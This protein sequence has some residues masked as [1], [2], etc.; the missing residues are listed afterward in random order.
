MLYFLLTKSLSTCCYIGGIS[1][2]L[3]H[4]LDQLKPQYIASISS[5]KQWTISRFPMSVPWNKSY[6]S[7]DGSST[8]PVIHQSSFLLYGLPEELMVR[9]R[10]TT[11][12]LIKLLSLT[13]CSTFSCTF[14]I[15]GMCGKK[16]LNYHCF[17]NHHSET[18]VT[19]LALP[20]AFTEAERARLRACKSVLSG[21]RFTQALP[22]LSLMTEQHYQPVLA[23]V[24]TSPHC[25]ILRFTTPV[26]YLQECWYVCPSPHMGSISIF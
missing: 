18:K 20:W 4:I 9:L 1:I 14:P 26:I 2:N 5:L 24:G 3:H 17:S 19:V 7:L 10:S 11:A 13:F 16:L 21:G 23:T 6:T 8:P 15:C 25:E 12:K 22:L